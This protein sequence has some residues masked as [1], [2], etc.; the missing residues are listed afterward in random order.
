MPAELAHQLAGLEEPGVELRSETVLERVRMAARSRAGIVTLSRSAFRTP[1]GVPCGD[2]RLERSEWVQDYTVDAQW[3]STPVKT[4]VLE[5]FEYELCPSQGEEGL[6]LQYRLKRTV[7]P[8][9]VREV[10]ITLSNGEQI[11]VHS[12]DLESRTLASSYELAEG[13]ILA[14]WLPG[15]KPGLVTLVCARA[16]LDPGRS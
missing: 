4:V 10:L 7:L 16:E 13:Q 12:L 11:K 5:G 15:S 9:P 6:H 3:K 1:A 14:A 2:S 8:R